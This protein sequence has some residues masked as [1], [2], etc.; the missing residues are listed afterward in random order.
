M[1][2][3]KV[4]FCLS[5]IKDNIDF[6]IITEKLKIKPTSVRKKS[7]FPKQSI[8]LGIALNEWIICTKN[9]DCCM[10]ISKKIDNIQ[11]LFFGKEDCLKTLV[12][13]YELTCTFSVIINVEK[14]EYPEMFLTKE[15]IKF[16][17][18][19]NAEIGFDLYID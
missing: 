1:S 8:D 10:S 11:N 9:D 17:S 19:I 13:D 14:N 4:F 16:M 2:K 12:K 7:D 6:K 5:S 15:N 18:Q 3:V